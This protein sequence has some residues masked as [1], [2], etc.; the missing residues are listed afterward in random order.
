MPADMHAARARAEARA[1]AR[2]EDMLDS[3]F[4]RSIGWTEDASPGERALALRALADGLRQG[5]T[6][7]LLKMLEIAIGKIADRIE[8]SGPDGGPI[9]QEIAGL[10][11]EQLA[12]LLLAKPKGGG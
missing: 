11:D 8:H 2:L 4:A 1:R 6:P 7:A 5:D 12:K 10:S 9:Q 3:A